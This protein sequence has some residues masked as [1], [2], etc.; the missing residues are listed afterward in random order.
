MELTFYDFES[1]TAS[2]PSA[3][4]ENRLEKIIDNLCKISELGIPRVMFIEN[5]RIVEYGFFM[6]C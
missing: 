2:E 6:V 4:L 5:T 3:S 1:K